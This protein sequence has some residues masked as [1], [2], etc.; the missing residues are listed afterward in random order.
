MV[1]N[2]WR[3]FKK[4]NER[5]SR[6]WRGRFSR[7]IMCGIILHNMAIDMD[8]QATRRSF[9]VDPEDSNNPDFKSRRQWFGTCHDPALTGIPEDHDPREINQVN[10]I[11][12]QTMSRQNVADDLADWAHL[13]YG[14]AEINHG[15]Y[16]RDKKRRD[17][18]IS[19]LRDGL[20]AVQDD[21]LM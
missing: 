21:M 20:R 2:R 15:L 12:S 8:D 3:M 18:M 11:Q 9:G 10:Y 13:T 17:A 1:V 5:R 4:T 16:I 6:D 7:L 14:Y 19:Q